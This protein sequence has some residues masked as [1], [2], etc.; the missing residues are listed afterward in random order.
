MLVVLPSTGISLTDG[1]IDELVKRTLEIGERTAADKA[2]A[3]AD[4]TIAGKIRGPV[5]S[6]LLRV[7]REISLAPS[8]RKAR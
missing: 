7:V 6:G 2:R 5:C 3:V 8:R 4:L 1:E